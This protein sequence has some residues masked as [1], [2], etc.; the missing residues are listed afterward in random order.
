LTTHYQLSFFVSVA[1]DMYVESE[2]VIGNIE[3]LK[4]SCLNSYS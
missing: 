1:H 2:P 4:S 3:L